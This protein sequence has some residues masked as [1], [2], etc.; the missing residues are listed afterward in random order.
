MW[1]RLVHAEARRELQ[2]RDEA[3]LADR[4]R[5]LAEAE[6]QG[7]LRGTDLQDARREDFARRLLKQGP[8]RHL[9]WQRKPN[10]RVKMRM[11]AAVRRRKISILQQFLMS[12]EFLA[13]QTPRTDRC[14]RHPD[15]WRPKMGVLV[16]TQPATKALKFQFQQSDGASRKDWRTARE[17]R[18]QA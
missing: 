16:T 7:E 15:Q 1:P 18:C 10:I 6:G 2:K 9:Q 5:E 13:Q 11:S 14:H 17:L 4:A 8:S 12:S 3:W